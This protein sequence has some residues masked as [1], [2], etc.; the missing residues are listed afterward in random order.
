MLP[1]LLE[2]EVPEL[3]MLPEEPLF[4]P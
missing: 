1:E 3:P 2:P 4:C